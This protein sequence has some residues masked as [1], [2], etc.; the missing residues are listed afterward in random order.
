MAVKLGNIAANSATI[1]VPA[2][3]EEATV[4]YYPGRIS[5]E[6]FLT[7]LSFQQELRVDSPTK[8]MDDFNF[9]LVAILK[10]WDL[11]EDD[12]ETVIPITLDK[13]KKIYFPFKMLV[14]GSVIRDINP[15]SMVP[16][17]K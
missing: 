4:E 13:I 9:A 16:G 17:A 10:G 15:E 5:D 11:V 8:F 1:R 14:I 12:G 6:M 7:L 2:G 3:D